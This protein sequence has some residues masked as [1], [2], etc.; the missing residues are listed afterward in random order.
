M[1]KTIIAIAAL[2]CAAS[3]QSW[4]LAME[5]VTAHYDIDSDSVIISGKHEAQKGI[6]FIIPANSSKDAAYLPETVTEVGNIFGK[7]KALGETKTDADGNFSMTFKI[8]P[9]S[10]NGMYTAYVNSNLEED[11]EMV[12]FKYINPATVEKYLSQIASA[13]TDSIAT[14]LEEYAKALELDLTAWN[15]QGESKQETA[16]LFTEV[17]RPQSGYKK[18][19]DLQKDIQKAVILQKFNALTDG[20][21]V[22]ENL[23]DA[24]KVLDI[25]LT[26][27]ER[28][29]SEATKESK[30]LSVCAELFKL[31]PINNLKEFSENI[32]KISFLTDIT[33]P[34][35]W[36]SLQKMT[37]ETYKDRLS[38]SDSVWK[39]YDSLNDKA[40]VFKEIYQKSFTDVNQIESLTE[41]KI[42]SKYSAQNSGGSGSGSGSGRGSS[43]GT[44]K[45][46]N[47]TISIPQ[48][49]STPAQ[50]NDVAVKDKFD[51]LK[52]AAWAKADIEK[53]ADKGIIS[54]DGMGNVYPNRTITREEFITM[55]VK[56]FE[57]TGDADI[58][59]GD[60]SEG[61][62][63]EKFVKAAFS[64]GIVSGISEDKFGIGSEITRQD[65]AV[66]LY[67]AAEKL[68]ISMKESD[69]EFT[70]MESAAE[71]AKKAILCMKESKII[72]GM[73][74]G[75][76]MPS[77]KATRA[78]TA[79]MINRL[80]GM[81]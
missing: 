12:K 7:V 66:I 9:T 61:T 43:G 19:S 57:L 48:P 64:S 29:G 41:S 62:W 67:R 81:R 71:Y 36:A 5:N 3:V 4:A 26:G 52:D 40:A 38:I 10:E 33:A 23:T 47:I 35:D 73:G 72:T 42:N 63:Y 28:I 17:I 68:G 56:A 53:L 75:R 39:K 76:F 51:D 70:D 77:E 22:K 31:L 30:Q 74:D 59:F 44:N 45:S 27:Y 14:M 8:A 6:M 65:M 2:L 49:P 20:A 25:D 80:L 11:A 79:V 50:G 18:V 60:V 55:V 69:S 54:G 32:D 13:D 15:D 21:A 37:T 34:E 78:Q 16:R 46:N 24:A 1:K 58:E